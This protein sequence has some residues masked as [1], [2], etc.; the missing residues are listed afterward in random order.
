MRKDEWRE[1]FHFSRRE[2][3]G[4]MALL[5]LVIL[6]FCLPSIINQFLPPLPEIRTLENER[7]VREVQEIQQETAHS[8]I[9]KAGTPNYLREN[10]EERFSPIKLFT[11]DPNTLDDEGWLSLGLNKRTVKTIRN[12]QSKGGKFRKPD[13][14]KRVY[15]IAPSLAEKLL[16]YV[17]IA[18][19]DKFGK[20]KYDSGSFVF[21][22]FEKP[23][24][25]FKR[26]VPTSI[27]IN[28]ADSLEWL[29]LDGIGPALTHRIL[30]FREKLGGFYTI[31]QI[32]EV[33]GLPDSTF[34]LV[35]PMLKCA[36]DGFR[37][38]PLNSASEAELEQHPY[39]RKKLAKVLIAYRTQHGPFRNFSDLGKIQLI[40]SDLLAKLVPYISVE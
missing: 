3:T 5:F 18:A 6:I 19:P 24:R 11:F 33:F 39:I 7:I 15:G 10:E 40:D 28:E 29:A 4:I 30:K 27:D 14:I 37:K 13:D 22:K 26:I 34:Q 25:E 17:S 35:K 36:P 9:E 31:N 38:I 21:K 32:A 2:T 12:Y 1:F 16:P 8:G 20:K 23:E